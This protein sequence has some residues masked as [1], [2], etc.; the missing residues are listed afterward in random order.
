MG[1]GSPSVHEFSL[2]FFLGPNW[3]TISQ[4]RG[5]QSYCS[6]DLYILLIS[7]KVRLTNIGNR[8][9]L[10]RTDYVFFNIWQQVAGRW[11]SWSNNSLLVIHAK[12]HV[13]HVRF[14]K[15]RPGTKEVWC[16]SAAEDH[17]L[18]LEKW[19]LTAWREKIG[20]LRQSFTCW[21]LETPYFTSFYPNGTSHFTSHFIFHECS[22]T[23]PRY[24]HIKP[25]PF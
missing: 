13:Y 11:S 2:V 23:S 7:L 15:H 18:A 3:D 6:Y 4:T 19:Y 21:K 16:D 8:N 17:L 9:R 20:S 25:A 12:G 10:P 22:M 24:L 14:T 5:I 1:S